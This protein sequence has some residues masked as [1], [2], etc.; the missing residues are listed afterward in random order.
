[1]RLALGI[2]KQNREMRLWVT[3]LS[4]INYL[5]DTVLIRAVEEGI[6]RNILFLPHVLCNIL[7]DDD[8][9]T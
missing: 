7:E 1:M 4:Y 3:E 6:L 8:A 5:N 2:N 9:E